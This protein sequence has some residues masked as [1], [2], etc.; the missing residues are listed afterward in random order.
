MWYTLVVK[1]NSVNVFDRIY[2]HRLQVSRFCMEILHPGEMMIRVQTSDLVTPQEFEATLNR[3]YIED[4]GKERFSYG[5]LLFWS[6]L[7][8]PKRVDHRFLII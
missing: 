1:G 4:V 2:A 7:V 3:W 6:R 5:A 8:E